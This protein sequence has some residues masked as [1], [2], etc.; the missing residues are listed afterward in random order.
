MSRSGFYAHL[1]KPLGLRCQEDAVIEEEIC[2]AFEESRQTY[3][4][5][6]LQ[7]ELRSKG[8]HCGRRR[9]ARLMRRKRLLARRKGRFVPRTTDSSKTRIPAPQLLLD[10]PPPTAPNQVWATDITYIPTREGVL[11]VAAEIDLFS[12]RVLGWAS[13]DN[14][15]TPLVIHALNNALAQAPGRLCNLI[16]HSDQG[17]Q[18]ASRDFSSLLKELSIDQSMSRRGNCYDNAFVESFWATLKTEC[19]DNSMPDTRAQATSMIFD[20]I[21][22][23]YNPVR[24]HSALGF[25][26]P[27]AFENQSRN[28]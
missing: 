5:P 7:V 22:T 27:V 15:E 20:Y 21:H 14:M 24:R 9:I 25:L 8:R 3:G 23:F 4:T 28:N 13:A 10:C 2:Q 11:Y 16:H 12:R 17:S 1:Q 18:Y 26:S 6:R 19:F